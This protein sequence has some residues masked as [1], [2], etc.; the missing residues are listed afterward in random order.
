L[1]RVLAIL[2]KFI[3][4]KR[5]KVIEPRQ[6]IGSY[7]KKFNMSDLRIQPA[8][9]NGDLEPKQLELAFDKKELEPIP[10]GDVSLTLNDMFNLTKF[11]ELLKDDKK[12]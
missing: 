6:I 7:R 8:I 12:E 3:L 1:P 9:D 11:T 10:F 5:N 2:V 4:I